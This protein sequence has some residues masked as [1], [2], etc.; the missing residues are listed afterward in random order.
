[1]IVLRLT[2]LVL[3]A[4]NISAC[5]TSGSASYFYTQKQ[6]EKGDLGFENRLRV[7]EYINAFPQDELPTPNPGEDLAVSILY[8][9][10][11]V[12][13]GQNTTLAQI[14]IK[15]RGLIKPEQDKSLGV[16]I[17]LDVS[18]SMRQDSKI[19]DSL[20]ALQSAVDEFREGTEF[21]LV[22]FSEDA[23]VR[24]PPTTITAYSRASIRSNI[25]QIKLAGGTNI[26][27]GLVLGYKTMASFSRTALSRLL[28]ITDG[29]SNVGAISPEEIAKQAGVQYIQGARISTVGLGHDVNERMLRKIATGGHGAYYFADRAATLTKILRDD[30][31][32]TVVAVA[33][34]IVLNLRAHPK[35]SIVSLYGYETSPSRPGGNTVVRFD[36]LNADDWRIL[37]AEVTGDASDG[38]ITPLTAEVGYKPVTQSGG[39]AEG[40]LASASAT[41][42]WH[43][44][45]TTPD[46]LNRAVARNAVV[47]ADAM[48]LVKVS[49]L[50]KEQ[51][52]REAFDLL[53]VQIANVQVARTWDD[54]DSMKNEEQTLR[55]VQGI[56]AS[57]PAQHTLQ[58]PQEEPSKGDSKAMIKD[59]LDIVASVV[60]GPWSLILKLFG[61]TFLRP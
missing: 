28:L 1:M 46:T 14:A 26:E 30:L 20:Q 27:A 47:F 40:R 41:V 31:K 32:T 19:Q 11:H 10:N 34:D 51:R 53:S 17:V 38:A 61:A 18:G 43:G 44:R 21:A 22:L 45:T 23:W 24:I 39:G 58:M 56:I 60:P 54:T 4:L 7:G 8:F 12:P 49:Q 13:S 16:C 9:S 15:T 36:E 55:R 25:A 48:A 59:V 57:R 5:A 2:L 50:D 29:Q 6:I 37:I 35:F 3:V 33:K 52:Y 42:Q